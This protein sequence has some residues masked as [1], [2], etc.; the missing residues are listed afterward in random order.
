MPGEKETLWMK[1]VRGRIKRKNQ[2]LFSKDSVL[3]QD[4]SAVIGVQNRRVL[5][6]WALDLAGEVSR[7]FEKR[8][9]NQFLPRNT[10]SMARAWAQGQIKMS[11]AKR[12]ILDCHALAKEMKEP[13]DIALCHAIAQGCSVVHTTGH[14]LGLPIYELTAIVRENG[15]DSCR[16]PVEDRCQEYVDKLLYWHQQEPQYEGP[17]ADFLA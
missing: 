10:V 3:L 2:I 8:H 7:I 13:V 12:A 17:W 1:E 16:E 14:A 4:L 9:P 15:I 11:A 6:L 5:T